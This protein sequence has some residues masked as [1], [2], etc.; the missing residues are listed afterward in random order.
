MDGWRRGSYNLSIN[1]EGL[2]NGG[3]GGRY[4]LSFFFFFFF[5]APVHSEANSAW[6][7]NSSLTDGGLAPQTAPPGLVHWQSAPVGEGH[8][9]RF[10]GPRK[11]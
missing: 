1:E 6:P 11:N 5:P 4:L 3:E 8:A 10:W 9:T 2:D 7:D